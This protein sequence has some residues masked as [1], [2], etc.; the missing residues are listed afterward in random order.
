VSLDRDAAYR[1]I[2]AMGGELG[3]GTLETAEGITRIINAKMEEGIRAVSTEQG[4]DLRDFVLVAFGG[5]GPVPAGRIAA[6]LKMASVVIPPAPGVTSALGLL[7]A[8][9]RRD[10]VRS[11]L[12]R[13]SD[14][15]TDELT[16]IHRD[17]QAQAEREFT[18]EGYTLAQLRMEFSIDVRY[19]GQGYELTVPVGGAS[20][21][22]PQGVSA[23]R[24]RFDA[25][26]EQL[27]GHAAPDEVAEAVN[28]RLR[29]SATVT[30]ASLRKRS[31]A[32]TPVA[33]AKTGERPVCFDSA[34][35]M[36]ACPIYDRRALAPGHR[37]DGPAV[38]EQLDSTTVVYPGQRARVDDFLN[39]I[40][41]VS[42]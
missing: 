20:D 1:A 33:A 3:L 36:V 8:D 22:G 16:A 42:P 12:R 34:R 30:K 14:L 38:V 6:D 31:A 7:M 35:G 10:Y 32:D 27:F 37:I 41:S 9:P 5:A 15:G 24:T 25:T 11:R 18:T 26:H 29:A 13:L 2:E 40:V 4:Y 21:V 39:I 19:L 28:Y 17:L 23:I